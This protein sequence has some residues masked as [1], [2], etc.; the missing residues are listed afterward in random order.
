MR[1]AETY[2]TVYG[3]VLAI[4]W[5]RRVL[6]LLAQGDGDETIAPHENT[7]RRPPARACSSGEDAFGGPRNDGIRWDGRGRCVG[8]GL[9]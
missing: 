7:R 3:A 4:R 8:G 5:H 6:F 1:A 2:V 9:E